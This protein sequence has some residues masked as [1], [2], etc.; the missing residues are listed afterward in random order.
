V[1]IF[2]A[3]ATGVIGRAVVPRL[4]DAGHTVTGLARSADAAARLAAAGATPARVDLFEPADL[5]LAVFGHDVVVNLAT[6]IPPGSSATKADAWVD[7]NRIRSTGSRNLVRAALVAGAAVYVQESIAFLYPDHGDRWVDPDAGLVP[8]IWTDAVRDAE[9][10][11]RSFA[12]IGGGRRSVVLRFGGFYSA[13]SEHTRLL[14]RAAVRGFSLDLGRHDAYFPVIHVD[15]AATAV[16]AAL[17]APSGT[18]DVVDDEPM[19]R[20]EH[21]EVWSQ[22]LH[23]RVRRLPAWSRRL[24]GVAAATGARSMRVS[25]RAFR[26]ATGW[27]P[28][29]PSVRESLPRIVAE[30]RAAAAAPATALATSSATSSTEAR[31]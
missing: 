11:A 27:Q 10:N 6:A 15:D 16:V 20:R 29:H 9:A 3:G 31:P 26:E 5:E 2:V 17:H 8:S 1:K 22:A 25:N 14:H 4:L 12:E 18:Y 28:A 7:N 21:A 13:D 24:T 19:T 23:R 30:L